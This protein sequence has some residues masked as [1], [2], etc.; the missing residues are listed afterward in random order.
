MK[1]YL[2]TVEKAKPILN[3]GYFFGHGTSASP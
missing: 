2:A 1:D 3:F